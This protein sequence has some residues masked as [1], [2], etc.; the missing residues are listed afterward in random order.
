MTRSSVTTGDQ[1]C[2]QPSILHF[3]LRYR[4]FLAGNVQYVISAQRRIRIFG[5]RFMESEMTSILVQ[6]VGPE[7]EKTTKFFENQQ[8]A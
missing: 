4:R 7:Q 2:G 1:N 8:N 3:G 6:G 5:K